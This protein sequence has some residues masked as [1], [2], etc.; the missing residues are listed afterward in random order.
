MS[1]RTDKCYGFEHRDDFEEFEKLMW[2]EE[3]ESL[4]PIA[5]STP[6]ALVRRATPLTQLLQAKK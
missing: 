6:D 5:P 1:N 3:V 2:G 4:R